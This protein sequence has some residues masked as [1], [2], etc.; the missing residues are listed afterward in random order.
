MQ[1]RKLRLALALAGATTLLATI[2]PATPA[3]AANATFQAGTLNIYNGLTQ[4]QFVNDLELITSK[5]DL[6]GLNEVNARKDFLQ[7]WAAN[8][9]WWFYAPGPS[10]AENEA[11]LA[12]KSMF[13]VLDKG[14]DFICD[15]NGPGDV[16]PA[17]YNNWVKYRHK[18]SGRVVFHL[19]FHANASIE[20]NGHPVD[21]PR[22]QCAEQQF[23]AIKDLAGRKKD[24]GQVI[25]SGDLNVDFSADRAVGYAKFPWQVFEANQL[26]NLRS[27][28]NLYGEKGTGTHG[29][30]HIDY[31]YFW[32]RVEDFQLMWMTD[33]RI[34]TG[35]NSDHNGVVADFAIDI[36]T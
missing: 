23:Q 25:V 10:Q 9:G 13:D 31:I 6:V 35:T 27:I 21:I 15:T 2:V 24:E 28:Y 34:I 19:N 5:A 29:N 32:K 11:L 30:R 22:T 20:D 17:R 36:I 33:Y 18:A 14:S 16:P 8:N 7:T 4:A 1:R 12:K 3:A 26:P